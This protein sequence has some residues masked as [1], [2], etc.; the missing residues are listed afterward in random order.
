MSGDPLKERG[1]LLAFAGRESGEEGLAVFLGGA[2]DITKGGVAFFGE[3]KGIGA[4]IVSGGAAFE[5]AAIF[6]FV[7]DGDEGAGMNVEIVGE[8]LLAEAFGAAKDAED[9]GVGGSEVEGGEELCEFAGGVGAELGKEEAGGGV[10]VGE[11][12]RGSGS[13]GESFRR[14]GFRGRLLSLGGSHQELQLH[15]R[16]VYNINDY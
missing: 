12:G 5:E 1:E 4:A 2:G 10:L 15:R 9:A 11:G 8:G 6:E 7:D 14:A 16:I 3:V 13:G